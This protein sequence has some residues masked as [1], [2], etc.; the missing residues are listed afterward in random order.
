M[1]LPSFAFNQQSTPAGDNGGMQQYVS[2]GQAALNPGQAVVA[3]AS[4]IAAGGAQDFAKAL[5]QL[6]TQ[7]SPATSQSNANN[8]AGTPGMG[9][10]PYGQQAGGLNTY[11]QYP[12]G[13]NGQS[14]GPSAP[15]QMLAQGLMNA[16]PQQPP[17]QI[18][19]MPGM[20]N[21]LFGGGNG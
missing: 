20:Q 4:P 21:Y 1:P 5:A 18:Q 17:Q 6:A 10:D 11:A 3:Q 8:P 12:T 19:G 7:Q 2:Q 16:A 14:A 13:V 9:S 15:Q